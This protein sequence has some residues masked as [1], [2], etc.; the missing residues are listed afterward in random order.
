M[1]VAKGTP[2]RST[3]W[4]VALPLGSRAQHRQRVRRQSPGLAAHATGHS[5]QG[6]LRVSDAGGSRRSY[7]N[8]RASAVAEGAPKVVGGGVSWLAPVIQRMSWPLPGV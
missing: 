6:H 2:L 7:R 4:C 8:G 5:R 3:R 1:R